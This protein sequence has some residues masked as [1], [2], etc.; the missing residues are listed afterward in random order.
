[1]IRKSTLIFFLLLPLLL[2]AQSTLQGS[3]YD[4]YTGYR[5]ANA[6]LSVKRTTLQTV[7]DKKGYFILK[8][9]PEGVW[10]LEIC[11]PGYV[12]LQKEI[13]IKDEPRLSGGIA[14]MPI[15]VHTHELSVSAAH[16]YSREPLRSHGA[17]SVYDAARIQA[18]APPS[19]T[20]ALARLPGI[21]T[22]RQDGAQATP[23]IRG[24]G[25]DQILTVQ[26]GIRLGPVSF[27]SP[28]LHAL[29]DI[30]SLERIEVL[31]GDGAAGW[32]SDALGGVIMLQSR[33]PAFS[34]DKLR[35]RGGA[36][37]RYQSGGMEQGFGTNVEVQS[38]RLA[39]SAAWGS[40]RFG[41]WQ[42]GDG[43]TQSP[44]AFSRDNAQ[45]RAKFR[46]GLRH[47]LLFSSEQTALANVP[48]YDRLRYQGFQLARH[49]L[50]SRHLSYLRWTAQF[51]GNWLRELQVTSSWQHYGDNFSS[52]SDSA[53]T[54]RRDEKLRV[55]IFGMQA[56]AHSQPNP[57]WHMVSGAELY[58][59]EVSSEAYL[60]SG[61][62]LESVRPSLPEAAR[63]STLALFN[64]HTFDLLKL[65]IRA[66][67]RAQVYQYEVREAT[68]ETAVLPATVSFSFSGQYPLNRHMHLGA[69]AY[70]G[71]RP[72]NLYERS[73]SAWT[74]T[75]FGTF[76]DSLRPERSFTTEISLKARTERLRTAVS[77]YRTALHDQIVWTPGT[78]EGS[79]TYQGAP[80]YVRKNNARANIQGIEAEAEWALS[81]GFYAYGS[82]N[83]TL[84][85]DLRSNDYLSQIPPL[86][87]RAGL[88]FQ[89]RPGLRGGAEWVFASSQQNISPY[90]SG[91]PRIP[92]GGSSAWNVVNLYVGMDFA[93]GAVN[94]SLSNVLDTYYLPLGSA[95]G[96]QGRTLLASLRIA[97]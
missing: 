9:I 58:Q 43:L 80:V 37:L 60:V 68:V 31:R 54:I 73:G 19:V 13:V 86:N 69:S 1:M 66:G 65:H 7:S 30:E 29:V 92:M 24:M 64:M 77:V 59:D 81:T 17:T 93:A 51:K 61:S 20:D 84:G 55:Q 71:A 11:R 27:R 48:A 56:L 62:D 74:E 47:Q 40:R 76:G 21:W 44:A 26:D 2:P 90:D 79:P 46:L 32:G 8:D 15:L 67:V 42:A 4:R 6:T 95:L 96:G 88:R 23:V 53:S 97:L 78:Y 38:P 12:P 75:G 36:Q 33:Q 94:L 41:N 3:V 85:F 72:A 50:V 28:Y 34:N 49:S 14:L 52:I 10:I 82:L 35:V 87:G 22:L 57:Y 83:Y 45:I 25:N 16:R 39:V 5:L 91:N 63:G 18:E 89:S 70:H